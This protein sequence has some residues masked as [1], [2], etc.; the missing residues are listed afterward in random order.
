MDQEKKINDY[1]EQRGMEKQRMRATRRAEAFVTWS[2][3]PGDVA[4]GG[5]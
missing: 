5:I 3:S 2:D 4:A 1:D